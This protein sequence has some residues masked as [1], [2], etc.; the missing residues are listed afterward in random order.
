M[1]RALSHLETTIIHARKGHY[2]SAIIKGLVLMAEAQMLIDPENLNVIQYLNEAR[3]LAEPLN[4][5][6]ELKRIYHLYGQIAIKQNDLPK[7]YEHYKRAYEYLKT[8]LKSINNSDYQTS[9]LAK[10]ENKTL[11]NDIKKIQKTMRNNNTSV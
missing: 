6:L 8:V 3:D 9:F 4:L 10:N 2:V 11:L 5:S 1:G 7:A